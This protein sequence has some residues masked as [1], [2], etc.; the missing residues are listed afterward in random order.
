MTVD[1]LIQQLKAKGVDATPEQIE[2]AIGST[3]YLTGDDIPGIIELLQPQSK[4]AKRGTPTT[5]KRGG[6][7]AK[8]SGNLAKAK[9]QSVTHAAASA[10]VPTE[11]RIDT[12]AY[13]NE[14][15]QEIAQP[16]I[17]AHRR[18]TA[19]EDGLDAAAQHLANR[20]QQA[21]DSFYEKVATPAQTQEL[22]HFFSQ[23]PE[24]FAM[25]FPSV[26]GN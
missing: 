17:E 22:S 24:E 1:E 3:A 23:I 8:A 2:R 14:L 15:A 16:L 9:P 12:A 13:Q 7:L 18:V 25:F 21:F 20:K 5:A 19:L 6:N 4:P 10:P 26:S 11:T